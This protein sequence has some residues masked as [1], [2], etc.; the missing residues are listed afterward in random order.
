MEFFVKNN[1]IFRAK[2]KIDPFDKS[3]AKISF[4]YWYFSG[5]APEVHPAQIYTSIE[6][7]AQWKLSDTTHYNMIRCSVNLNII[8]IEFRKRISS[9]LTQLSTAKATKLH[10]VYTKWIKCVQ[11]TSFSFV[12]FFYL[13][14]CNFKITK[15]KI[16][17][18]ECMK[19]A[20]QKQRARINTMQWDR[21]TDRVR[22]RRRARARQYII[23]LLAGIAWH[24][25]FEWGAKVRSV[26]STRMNTLIIKVKTTA[27]LLTMRIVCSDLFLFFC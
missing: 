2:P 5:H 1:L 10:A 22:E 9:Y 19:M 3:P 20:V 4:K 26:S 27:H 11:N 15:R 8:A 24:I 13:R 18:R 23:G 16:T 17:K 21:H 14:V 7:N 6:L 12:F 25:I